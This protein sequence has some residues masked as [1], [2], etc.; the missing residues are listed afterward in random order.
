MYQHQYA[1]LPLEQLED[2]PQPVVVLL[3]V[4][5]DKDPAGRFQNP[6]ALVKM[7]PPIMAALH[8][9]GKSLGI[10]LQKTPFIVSRLGTRRPPT[11]LAPAWLVQSACSRQKRP[12]PIRIMDE[13]V[14]GC[15]NGDP[16]KVRQEFS[17]TSSSSAG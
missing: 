2:F 13:K 5:L 8:A 7:I 16:L 14:G 3:E 6:A 17:E 12:S 10:A 4:L 11:E 9:A 1:P 15:A